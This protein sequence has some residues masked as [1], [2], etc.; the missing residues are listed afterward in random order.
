MSRPGHPCRL[1]VEDAAAIALLKGLPRLDNSPRRSSGCHRVHRGH[2]NDIPGT[3]RPAA[4]T[5]PVCPG[6]PVRVAPAVAGPEEIRVPIIVVVLVLNHPS[7]RL[8]GDANVPYCATL[9]SLPPGT[10]P[11]PGD[12][13]SCGTISRPGG[14][15]ASY[16]TEVVRMP[17]RG[18]KD[19]EMKRVPGGTPTDM[20]SACVALFVRDLCPRTSSP[21][22]IPAPRRAAPES[23]LLLLRCCCDCCCCY[24]AP[25]RGDPCQATHWRRSSLSSSL[26]RAWSLPDHSLCCLIDE[27]RLEIELR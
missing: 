7:F 23:R 25:A 5:V 17:R 10:W 22:E 14:S 2:A 18:A 9:Q 12:H 8:R 26:T 11:V 13:T 19:L 15:L 6:V 27:C 3:T 4:Y 24:E 16:W 20:R 21:R 1:S